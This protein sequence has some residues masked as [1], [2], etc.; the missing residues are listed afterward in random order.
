MAQR[1]DRGSGKR[2]TPAG[3]VASSHGQRGLSPAARATALTLATRNARFLAHL[4]PS[5][6]IGSAT[7]A[8]AAG[9]QRHA[10]PPARATL[11][12][13]GHGRDAAAFAAG[14]ERR[15]GALSESLW[16]REEGAFAGD[17]DLGLT[18]AR[19]TLRARPARQSAGA[20]SDGEALAIPSAST[21]VG[22]LAAEPLPRPSNPLSASSSVDETAPVPP[23]PRRSLS[24]VDPRLIRPVTTLTTLE[25]AT[26]PV[27]RSAAGVTLPDMVVT[28]PMDDRR[29]QEANSGIA[30]RQP[31]HVM[32]ALGR[33]LP[34]SVVRTP[35]RDGEETDWSVTEGRQTASNVAPFTS[36]PGMF[37]LA[38]SVQRKPEPGAPSPNTAQRVGALRQAAQSTGQPLDVGTR[39]AMQTA[40]G[41]ELPDVRVHADTAAAEAASALGAQAFTLG[42]AVYF[43]QGAFAPHTVNGAALLGHELVHTLQQAAPAP[44]PQQQPFQAQGHGAVRRADLEQA[45]DDS[46]GATSDR[47]ATLLPAG[48]VPV[49]AAS[50]R[51]PSAVDAAVPIANTPA[52]MAQST[53]LDTPPGLRVGI[54]SGEHIALF[55]QDLAGV[56]VAQGSMAYRAAGP[57]SA[58]V[59][60]VPGPGSAGVSPVPVTSGPDE[61]RGERHAHP[62]TGQ[63]VAVG[64]DSA[65]LSS[66]MGGAAVVSR[67]G[68]GRRGAARAGSPVGADGAGWGADFWPA[69]PGM[70]LLLDGAPVGASWSVYAALDMAR[71]LNDTPA[72]MGL[73]GARSVDAVDAD[74]ARAGRSSPLGTSLDQ[75]AYAATGRSLPFVGMWGQVQRPVSNTMGVGEQRHAAG[76]G[77]VDKLVAGA[78][79]VDSQRQPYVM[80]PRS[81]AGAMSAADALPGALDLAAA[82]GRKAAVAMDMSVPRQSERHGAAPGQE[83]IIVARGRF[84]GG[85]DAGP[86]GMRVSSLAGTLNSASRVAPI[87][88]PGDPAARSGR[89]AQAPDAPG[90]RSATNGPRGTGSADAVGASLDGPS[91]TPVSFGAAPPMARV[92]ESDPTRP[93]VDGAAMRRADVLASGMTAGRADVFAMGATEAALIAQ[94]GLEAGGGDG[95][96][97]DDVMAVS[98]MFPSLAGLAALQSHLPAALESVSTSR[99]Q[100]YAGQP[101]G[102][103]YRGSWQPVFVAGGSTPRSLMPSV[104]APGDVATG[105]TTGAS[106]SGRTG[107]LAPAATGSKMTIASLSTTGQEVSTGAAV[108]GPGMSTDAADAAGT[109]GQTLYHPLQ[110]TATFRRGVDLSRSMSASADPFAESLE[111]EDQ[112]ARAESAVLRLFSSTPM[113]RPA[114]SMATLSPATTGSRMAALSGPS[115][116]GPTVARRSDGAFVSSM[117][118]LSLSYAARTGAQTLATAGERPEEPVISPAPV[119]MAEA[120]R[121]V[122]G[123]G[124]AAPAD[125]ASDTVTRTVE[126]ISTD[127][128]VSDVQPGRLGD[129]FIPASSEQAGGAQRAGLTP[130]AVP[131]PDAAGQRGTGPA[132]RA[133]LTSS[134]ADVAAPAV[135]SASTVSMSADPFG[136]AALD[137]GA[138][139]QTA[140][141]GAMG[142]RGPVRASVDLLRFGETPTT[143]EAAMLPAGGQGQGRFGGEQSRSSG[144]LSASVAGALAGSTILP[145]MVSL[146]AGVQRQGH[147][148]ASTPALQRRLEVL[149][150]ASSGIGAGRPPT[151]AVRRGAETAPVRDFSVA[152]AYADTAVSGG[153]STAA[154][155]RAFS[156]SDAT[157]ILGRLSPIVVSGAAPWEHEPSRAG[158]QAAGIPGVTVAGQNVQSGA[159]S[160]DALSSMSEAET[161]RTGPSASRQLTRATSG[162]T[163]D[164]SPFVSPSMLTLAAT[165][166]IGLESPMIRTATDLQ[167][168]TM[169]L[170]RRPVGAFV[171]ASWGTSIVRPSILDR[172]SSVTLTPVAQPSESNASKRGSRQIERA[173]AQTPTAQPGQPGTAVYTGYSGSGTGIVAWLPIGVGGDGRVDRAAADRSGSGSRDGSTPVIRTLTTGESAV[174]EAQANESG[175]DVGRASG[176]WWAGSAV[177]A[178]ARLARV[179]SQAGYLDGV[180]LSSAVARLLNGGEIAPSSEAGGPGGNSVSQRRWAESGQ[181][182]AGGVYRAPDSGEGLG[183]R[184][185]P[186]DPVALVTAHARNGAPGG[187]AA[188]TGDATLSRRSETVGR[189]SGTSVPAALAGA[190]A[191]SAMLPGMLSLAASVQRKAEA[192]AGASRMQTLGQAA[193][194]AH[195][196]ELATHRPEAPARADAAASMGSVPGTQG[197]VSAVARLLDDAAAGAAGGTGLDVLSMARRGDEIGPD[198]IGRVHRA[199]VDRGDVAARWS[200]SPDPAALL[201]AR[202]QDGAPG[203]RG[204]E[205]GSANSL[206]RSEA[207]GRDSGMSALGAPG[208]LSGAMATSTMLPG[209]LSLAASVQRKAEAGAGT[210]GLQRRLQALEHV[211]GSTGRPLESAVRRGME[212]VLGGDLSGVR[213]HADTAAASA[214]SMLGARA[215]ALGNAVYFSQ[216]AFA[217]GT[218]AGAALLAHELVHTRQQAAGALDAPQR[219]ALPGHEAGEGEPPEL[220]AHAQRTEASVL[221]LFSD[222]PLARQADATGGM[223]GGLA[224]MLSRRAE[225]SAQEA[226]GG[227]SA[228]GPGAMLRRTGIATTNAGAVARTAAVAEAGGSASSGGA[229]AGGMTVI[230]LPGAA[231]GAAQRAAQPDPAGGNAAV[232]RQSG[233]GVTG[234]LSQAGNV[235]GH[236]L[237]GVDELVGQ[238][239][240]RVRRQIALDHERAGGFLSDLM[241]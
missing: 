122:A 21:I 133:G 210:P 56:A 18:V 234:S 198:M 127:A 85:A 46:V 92:S 136:L 167:G 61:Q 130:S 235:A 142:I 236:A 13:P 222:A 218:A 121:R 175:L 12:Q 28:R 120:V 94:R 187:R 168:D 151:P 115:S 63:A 8:F 233:D 23:S 103:F 173:T 110:Q 112:A 176:A 90:G 27:L 113:A 65:A 200:V 78:G 230:G 158:Q 41:A 22:T 160:G 191:A 171:G 105:L 44:A 59:S 148:G 221:R 1:R 106:A 25:T 20:P 125:R 48:D 86:D 165:P 152:R 144:A 185:T 47:G 135:P 79:N 219:S 36:L 226:S 131:L 107:A 206:R 209:M 174:R 19:V 154:P 74:G 178:L 117:P 223:G 181:D 32:A 183:Q 196:L 52:A 68:S 202:V 186:P 155:T 229:L 33:P 5:S 91:A 11:E 161:S 102:S 37:D 137:L 138:R 16:P 215:F 26:R 220:E 35:P 225:G 88:L 101:D 40:L 208:E 153:A 114:V 104:A 10:T 184:A 62:D 38:A 87:V 150:Q 177:P 54:M 203:A 119:G 83:P 124:A 45:R 132:Q 227:F 50:A 162:R 80:T 169:T 58:G 51:L 126:T 179:Q 95:R 98:T 192:G 145:G 159:G 116:G 237:S 139:A 143:P 189:D 163:A 199:L 240:D 214:A 217:P 29:A 195:T 96:V 204:A 207:A 146:A 67:T 9:V 149:E 82:I 197:R 57:G 157:P 211:A 64:R 55:A 6:P 97:A 201:M 31:A 194:A 205:T 232:S 71:V 100:S 224:D 99:G 111:L 172:T 134:T 3:Q 34:L 170:S 75:P 129:Q 84:P 43:A 49:S 231:G 180:G 69:A 30:R 182:I 14:V 216:G 228:A 109:L 213:V 72:R 193:A 7:S 140:W 77:N 17:S 39:R 128:T 42:D 188:N 73:Y 141:L 66:L 76:A 89:E 241:R 156:S 60:P 2:A 108:L 238:V 164:A 93:A 118:A 15:Y 53:P 239:L 147:V 4:R 190:M 166:L 70:G 123:T 24:A 212:T 81:V